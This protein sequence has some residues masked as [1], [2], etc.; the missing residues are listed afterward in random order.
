MAFKT[1]NRRVVYHSLR[2]GKSVVKATHGYE[3]ERPAFCFIS[4]YVFLCLY[5]ADGTRA[6]SFE[7]WRAVL[8]LTELSLLTCHFWTTWG[9]GFNIWVLQHLR[10]KQSA[11]RCSSEEVTEGEV[12]LWKLL[13]ENLIKVK[14]WSIYRFKDTCEFVMANL[15]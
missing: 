2:S 1:I 9:L 8:T 3:Y 4:S 6:L 10:H 15:K 12:I 7:R 13:P 5:V 11:Y 14:R